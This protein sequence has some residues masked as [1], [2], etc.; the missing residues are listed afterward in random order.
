MIRLKRKKE[1]R[2]PLDARDQPATR[3]QRPRRGALLGSQGEGGHAGLAVE[4][5]AGGVGVGQP[6]GRRQLAPVLLGT[7]QQFAQIDYGNTDAISEHS[8][9]IKIK[10]WNST[11]SYDG[12][13]IHQEDVK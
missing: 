12:H 6:K 1:I 10:K 7:G 4:D 11:Y 5:L 9:K 2:R 8:Y 13:I 3:R